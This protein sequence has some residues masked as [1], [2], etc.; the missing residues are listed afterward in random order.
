[1]ES[2][3][4]DWKAIATEYITTRIS[5]R[6]LAKKYNV[7]MRTLTHRASKEKWTQKRE[8]HCGKVAAKTSEKIAD[9]QATTQANRLLRVVEINDKLLDILEA[10]SDQLSRHALPV[11]ETKIKSTK[12]TTT[13]TVKTTLQYVDGDVDRAELRHITA[14][15]KNIA[16]VYIKEREARKDDESN[17]G[18]Q[19]IFT[20]VDSDKAEDFSG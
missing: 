1:M 11:R 4:A 8:Q 16:D 15:M 20:G 13:R 9:R 18:T 2:E 14:A 7:S 3:K 12:T 6:E 10:A 17:T 5:Q 19:F